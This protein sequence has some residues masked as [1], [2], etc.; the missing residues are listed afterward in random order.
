M[1]T[2]RFFHK[3]SDAKRPPAM[4]G[5]PASMQQPGRIL[6]PLPSLSAAA[7]A[8][9]ASQAPLPPEAVR[10][11]AEQVAPEIYLMQNNA[12]MTGLLLGGL[13]AGPALGTLVGKWGESLAERT[14]GRVAGTLAPPPETPPAPTGG[15]PVLK[16]YRRFARRFPLVLPSAARVSFGVPAGIAG[17]MLLGKPLGQFFDEQANNS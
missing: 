7:R 16:G 8:G 10:S 13:I 1:S 5:L 14:Q 15:G 17:A 6:S 3:V 11:L 2:Q 9:S 4:Q 12:P